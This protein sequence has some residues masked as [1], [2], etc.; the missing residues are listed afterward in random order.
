MMISY[1]KILLKDSKIPIFI[2]NMEQTKLFVSGKEIDKY[3]SDKSYWDGD[4]IKIPYRLVD[5]TLIKSITEMKMDF[6]YCVLV[7]K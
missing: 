5:K 3:G 6:M 4:T 1:H 2:E 7:K